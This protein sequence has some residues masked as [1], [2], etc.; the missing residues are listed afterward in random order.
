M[1]Q[2]NTIY[3][4][5]LLFGVL[6]SSISQV[7][8]KKSAQKEYATKLLEYLNPLVIIAYAIFIGTT[9]LSVIAYRGIPLSIGP[10]L[11]A[12]S[13]LYITI[14]GVVFFKEKINVKKLLALFFIISGIVVYA[15]WG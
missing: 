14:F 8:L 11:E 13:Y 4:M 12:T 7:M 15:L 9:F 1:S 2:V 5:I 3:V 10:I 6:L